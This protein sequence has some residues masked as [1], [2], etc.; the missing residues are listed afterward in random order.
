MYPV[1]LLLTLT[2]FSFKMSCLVL[3][4]GGGRTLLLSL[5]LALCFWRDCIS[6]LLWRW[7][8]LNC[9]EAWGGERVGPQIPVWRAGSSSRCGEQMGGGR[10][11]YVQHQHSALAGSCP[12]PGP[13]EWIV[14]VS[15]ESLLGSGRATQLRCIAAAYRNAVCLS[16]SASNTSPRLINKSLWIQLRSQHCIS[17]TQVQPGP[18]YI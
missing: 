3:L 10:R 2:E 6:R 5:L 14:S 16:N 15:M 8:V 13:K 1:I 12:C 4:G 11:L 18:H 7:S 17:R 9:R